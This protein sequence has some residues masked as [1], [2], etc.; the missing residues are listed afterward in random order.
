MKNLK[1]FV[2]LFTIFLIITIVP[3]WLGFLITIIIAILYT[4]LLI[5]ELKIGKL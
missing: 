1:L 5:Y 2:I 4:L 3:I